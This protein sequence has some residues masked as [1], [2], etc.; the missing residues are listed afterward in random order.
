[1]LGEEEPYRE[2]P[3]FFSDLADWTGMEYVGPCHGWDELIFR[4]DRDD[5][6]FSAW[7]IQDGRVVAALAVNRS[8]DLIPARA[9]IE[10]GKDVSSERDALA[11]VDSDL[12]SI[13][14]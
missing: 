10:S 8:D 7:Y 14:D 9:L 6:E 12:G 4:G 2:V 11:D 5:A 1:M 13:S 3:Y